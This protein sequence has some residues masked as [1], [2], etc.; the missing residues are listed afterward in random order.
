[1]NKETVSNHTKSLK[2]SS[3]AV[4]NK[5]G[6]VFGDATR[7]QIERYTSENNEQK[8]SPVEP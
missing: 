5:K 4:E 2:L 1:M 6:L 3:K 7:K 8:K